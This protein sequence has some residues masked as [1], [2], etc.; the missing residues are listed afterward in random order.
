[1]ITGIIVSIFVASFL[2]IMRLIKKAPKFDENE[3]PIKPRV[4]ETAV[5]KKQKTNQWFRRYPGTKRRGVFFTFGQFT[6]NRTN[7]RNRKKRINKKL[8]NQ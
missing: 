7:Q 4:Q 6:S 1:M 2:V 5:P 8:H 3:Q